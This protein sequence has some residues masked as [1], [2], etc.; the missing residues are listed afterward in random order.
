M[1]S[2]DTDLGMR[3][4]GLAGGVLVEGNRVSKGALVEGLHELVH[5]LEV[6]LAGDSAEATLVLDIDVKVEV[7]DLGDIELEHVGLGDG[8]LAEVTGAGHG[9]ALS[10]DEGEGDEILNIVVKPSRG[11]VLLAE[12]DDM[13]AEDGSI[14]TDGGGNDLLVGMGL[15]AVAGLAPRDSVEVEEGDGAGKVL[16]DITE[17]GIM[18]PWLEKVLHVGVDGVVVHQGLDGLFKDKD[19]EKQLLV[20]LHLCSDSEMDR[21]LTFSVVGKVLNKHGIRQLPKVGDLGLALKE[22][23]F[24]DELGKGGVFR[25]LAGD[26]V[27]LNAEESG[28]VLDK[29]PDELGVIG[30][31]L[32]G[33]DL[34]EKDTHEEHVVWLSGDVV[35]LENDL[36]LGSAVML[37]MLDVIS[38]VVLLGAVQPLANL[39]AKD[40][41]DISGIL[42]IG[43][44]SGLVGGIQELSGVFAVHIFLVGIVKH[45]VEVVVN[46]E[47]NGSGISETSQ[48]SLEIDSSLL[49][50]I[51][52][53]MAVR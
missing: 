5:P 17:E 28:E 21:W 15:A 2:E 4:M 41:D 40:V 44:N 6:M 52:G 32:F 45:L 12:H 49:V 29:T 1:F 22:H 42:V 30:I 37:G 48:L 9:V 50:F 34:P 38:G 20:E 25:H 7:L 14:L 43:I 26:E 19:L 24:L 18:I 27:L 51:D 11:A 47:G 13:V 8:V 39:V 3:G 33:E 23:V 31:E 53:G 46:G 36:G 35:D 10:R 16:G